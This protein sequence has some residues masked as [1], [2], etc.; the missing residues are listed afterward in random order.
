MANVTIRIRRD[1]TANWTANNPVLASGEWAAEIL[2]GTTLVNIKIGDGITSWVNLAYSVNF[3][4]IEAAEQAASQ[5]ATNAASSAAAAAASANA[6][7]N[8]AKLYRQNAT[9]YAVGDVVLGADGLSKS[10]RL[11]CKTAGTTA[12]A[13]P[14][15]TAVN[16][17]VTDGTV[18]WEIKN[19]YD[20]MP[21]ISVSAAATIADYQLES[22]VVLSGSTT[23]TVTL[24]APTAPG[25][26]LLV[27][28]A[29]SVAMTLSTPSGIFDG[30]NGTSLSAMSLPSGV[31][32]G[33]LSDGT[34]W[35]IER[36]QVNWNNYYTK[37]EVD[38]LVGADKN[39]YGSSF[40]GVNY[41]GTRLYASSG[42]SWAPSTDAAAGTD[43]F[44][45][46]SVWN[47]FDVLV[48]YDSASSTAK[49]VAYEGTSAFDTYK[50][51]DSYGADVFHMFPK[52]YFQ[53]IATDSVGA[54]TKLVSTKEYANFS[55]SPMHYR[56][57]VLH[58]YIGITKYGWCDDGNGGICSRSGKPPKISITEN[59]FETLARA[60]GLRVGGINDVSWLQHIG[61]IKYNSLNWQNSVG[62]GVVNIYAT[63]TAT[64]TESGASRI[65]VSN[66]DAAKFSVGTLVHISS[67]GSGYW[68]PISAIATYDTSNMA[69]TVTSG[70]TFNTTS[71]STTIETSCF[72]S[73]GTD[74]VLGQDGAVSAGTDGKRSILTM[75]IENF[76][77]NDYKLLS[78]ACRIG[79][80]IYINPTPDTQYAWPSS[81]SDAL[82]K[83]WVK[84]DGTYCSSS[85][86]ISTFGYDSNY[87]HI[88]LPATVGG[89]SAVPVGDYYYTNTDT[90]AKVVLFG[91]CLGSGSG[92]GPF[93]ASLNGV[94][95]YASWNFGALGVFIP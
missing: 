33:L 40:D 92:A 51:D 27:R 20:L 63:G 50:N 90:N 18:I 52:G 42:L 7:A 34:N 87:P 13:A 93:C 66:T 60:K 67:V 29:G 68:W 10:L 12:S 64:V 6:A 2:T 44:T 38:A 75:G 32:C 11:V 19:A 56:G 95:G 69:I 3:P 30:P 84:Y 17:T 35:V 76:Y 45:G 82:S 77:G 15:W 65:I 89:S 1:T 88:L 80:N 81:D 57:G 91:G 9:A 74:T 23:Y 78:G 72:E 94:V 70:T 14:T 21:I 24:P 5:Y 26:T 48:K 22:C 79:S 49:I 37:T 41:T 58:D 53:R 8:V 59:N 25:H 39:I 73:G 16:T 55:P 83:G 71:G 36:Y 31:V 46:K 4:S 43:Q 61:C 85:G 86:Y 28:N 54:E 47:G 62:Q